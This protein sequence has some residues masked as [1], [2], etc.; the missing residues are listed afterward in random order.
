M[1]K[2]LY[3]EDVEFLRQGITADLSQEADFEVSSCDLKYED[4]LQKVAAIKPDVLLLDVMSPTNIH[5]GIRIAEKLA[6][7][8]ERKTGKLK[9]LLLTIFRKDD[10]SIK[11]A[12]ED[13]YADDVVTKPTTSENIIY[14]IRKISGN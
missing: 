1:P 4:T 10:D 9:I 12:L 7:T 3:A 6:E 11:Q 5:E 13:G 2:V 8:L 14:T